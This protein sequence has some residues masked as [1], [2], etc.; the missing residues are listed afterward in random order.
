MAYSKMFT[1]WF[2]VSIVAA[3]MVFAVALLPGFNLPAVPILTV[4]VSLLH[5]CMFFWIMW[6]YIMA[7]PP[8]VPGQHGLGNI[9]NDANEIWYIAGKNELL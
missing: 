2:V 4:M 8:P 5:L 9:S 3:Y 7:S 1:I 6:T